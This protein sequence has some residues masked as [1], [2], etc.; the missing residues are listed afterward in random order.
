[1]LAGVAS[2]SAFGILIPA[3][4]NSSLINSTYLNRRS[5]ITNS[6]LSFWDGYKILD[7]N[8]NIKK[9]FQDHEAKV[10][11]IIFSSNDTF[12]ATINTDNSVGLW[13][14]EGNL[15][16]TLPGHTE[17]IEE[18]VF[19][20]DENLI[21]SRGDDNLIKLWNTGKSSVKVLAGH[22]KKIRSIQ[23]NPNND[24][25]ISLSGESYSS[26]EIILWNKDGNARKV[27][28][29]YG[30]SDVYFSPN[31]EYFAFFNRFD[32]IIRV[33]NADGEPINEQLSGHIGRIHSISF[34][35]DGNFIVSGGEDNT[36]RLWSIRDGLIN[37]FR[38]HSDAILDVD[39]NPKN[40]KVIASVSKDKT[41]RIWD[42]TKSTP[43]EFKV[44][45]FDPLDHASIEF[46]PDGE[47][48]VFIG[49][50]FRSKPSI[51]YKYATTYN[52]IFLSINGEELSNT[53][54]SGSFGT[55]PFRDITSNANLK[56][57]LVVSSSNQ[58]RL[59][60]INGHL[61]AVMNGHNNWINSLDFSKDDS[62][63]ASA[64][65]DGT[66]KVWNADGSFLRSLEGH[67]GPVNSVSFHPNGQLIAS[68]GE[69]ETIKLWNKSGKLLKTLTDHTDGVVGIAFHPNGKILASVSR[70]NT[71][72][73]WSIDKNWSIDDTPKETLVLE[74][75]NTS[76]ID[77]LNFNSDGSL[78]AFGNGT[79]PVKLFLQN[80]IFFEETELS[81]INSL[82]D[83][84][85]LSEYET[86]TIANIDGMSMEVLDL[87]G[88]I[89]QA[90]EWVRD[91][92][93]SNS[94]VKES[95]RK[96][97]DGVGINQ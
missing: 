31:G 15:I 93:K 23:F 63:I 35:S 71:L 5:K 96:L 70:D 20:P 90:C 54:I 78:L 66:V 53:V 85:F 37:S 79:S 84:S 95:D 41:I 87:D 32:S 58:L 76:V 2:Q 55:Y 91:Y 45:N 77:S 16:S 39:F 11:R 62:T 51:E 34:S 42:I 4:S 72:K 27:L 92:L 86:K 69:D 38:G 33:F 13:D 3:I 29:T 25:L 97:C 9:N 26:N 19:S 36:V 17:K 82:S 88:S 59:S 81:V 60:D 94:N 64:S 22:T 46:S 80:A 14:L 24:F 40:N 67:D 75:V 43:Y 89:A 74:R 49:R 61:I 7:I 8:G 56:R 57:F 50:I 68:V 47:S 28:R 18:V 6:S 44:D 1:M 12:F 48:I 83:M 73:L 52:L 65:D 21:V 10:S 30:V